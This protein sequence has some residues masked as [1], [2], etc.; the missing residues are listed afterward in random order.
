V[1]EAY[2][3]DAILAQEPATPTDDPSLARQDA[4]RVEHRVPQQT[5]R[6]TATTNTKAAGND[7]ATHPN[8]RQQTHANKPTESN[9]PDDPHDD[10]V[11]G[12]ARESQAQRHERDNRR[13]HLELRASDTT[14]LETTPK[15]P[16]AHAIANTTLDFLTKKAYN[17][18][19]PTS[20]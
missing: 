3:T 2:P 11:D 17:P 16:K 13:S 15:H 9:Q 8:A 6:P 19:K 12:W 14:S 10:E 1:S 20:S 18:Y 7:K 5:T 4:P